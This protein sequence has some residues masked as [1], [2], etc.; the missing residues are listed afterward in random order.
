MKTTIR[1]IS[2]AAILLVILGLSLACA[3]PNPSPIGSSG[4]GVLPSPA[5]SVFKVD[6]LAINPAEVNAGVQ[7]LITAKVTNTG[8]ASENYAAEVKVISPDKPSLPAYLYS[9]EVIIPS[10]GSQLLSVSA[11]INYPGL[12]KVV[13]G[14]ASQDLKVNQDEQVKTASSPQ[15]SAPGLAPDFTAV[16]VVTGNT[17]TLGQFKGTGVLLNF[18]NYGCSPATN[19]VVSAQLMAIKQLKSQRSDFVPVSVFCGCCPPDILRQFAKQ[20]NLDWPWILDT[21]YSIVGKYSNYLKK[22]GYPTLVFV[23]KNMQVTEV[24]GSTNAAALA[25]K[26][27]K[28]SP[29]G[30]NR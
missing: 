28:I 24:A 15:D 3:S 13:W 4:T 17:I 1:L 29:Q 19:D 27:N 2:I 30:V 7:A 5:P 11:T 6:S 22:Y 18:V 8:S 21:D 9:N 16:D 23:D 25:D 14:G 26:I 12:Y 10:G 20:N